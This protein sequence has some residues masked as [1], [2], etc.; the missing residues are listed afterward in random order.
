MWLPIPL[1]AVWFFVVIPLC[2]GAGQAVWVRRATR[3]LPFA[4][5]TLYGILAWL[6][7]AWISV[8]EG[9]NTAALILVYLHIAVFISGLV[10]GFIQLIR[11][12]V[13]V[14]AA[15]KFYVRFVMG[16]FKAIE[17]FFA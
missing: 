4:L 12:S 8:W 14:S 2:W 16:L 10:S 6:V 9:Y 13:E 5:T 1:L 11:G 7:T 17:I 3:L 15:P